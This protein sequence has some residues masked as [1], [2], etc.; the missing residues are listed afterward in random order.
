MVEWLARLALCAYPREL[1]E[2][3][4]PEMLSMMLDIWGDSKASFAREIASLVMCGLRERTVVVARVGTRRIVAD[5]CGIAVAILLGT[6]AW[7]TASRIDVLF[8]SGTPAGDLLTLVIWATL[9]LL[10]MG[11]TRAVG[12]IGVVLLAP[13]ITVEMLN[14]GR[15]FANEIDPIAQVGL[16]LAFCVVM[17]ATPRARERHPAGVLWLVPILILGLLINPLGVHVSPHAGIA[18]Q[19]LDLPERILL[20]VTP[21]GL[22]RLAYDPRLALGCGLVWAMYALN[23][24][25]QVTVGFADTQWLVIW[26]AALFLV[27][28]T[29]RLGLMRWRT[30]G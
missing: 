21:L 7:N 30:P 11:Y 25:Y 23:N 16:L 17:A 1:R 8:T 28:G 20:A 27:L 5:S 26:A 13:I 4:G 29:L 19:S 10:L 18:L 15:G 6:T 22:L 14:K 12:V 9:A 24:V 3:K 2:S